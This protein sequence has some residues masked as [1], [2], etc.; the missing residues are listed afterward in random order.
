[1][2]PLPFLMNRQHMIAMAREILHSLNP[3]TEQEDDTGDAEPDR[4]PSVGK[5]M[6]FAVISARLQPGNEES[7]QGGG[8]H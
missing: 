5:G 8:I 4:I 2:L 3:T 1:M 6:I 7:Y